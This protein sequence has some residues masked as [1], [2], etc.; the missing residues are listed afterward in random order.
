[1]DADTFFR[2]SPVGVQDALYVEN[3][4]EVDSTM[5]WPVGTLVVVDTYI[6]GSYFVE[7]N[8]GITGAIPF[9]VSRT[10]TVIVELGKIIT[11]DDAGG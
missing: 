7:R 1:M 9:G 10:D 8:F 4:V 6:R 5:V 3:F 11:A 2:L